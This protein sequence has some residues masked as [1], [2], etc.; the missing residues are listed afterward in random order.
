MITA[1][2][3]KTLCAV[4]T[5]EDVKEIVFSISPNSATGLDGLFARFYQHY[6]DIIFADLVNMVCD[7][8][9]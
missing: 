3:N 5:G 2:D 1:E 7:F 6:R 8:F 9:A 4:P